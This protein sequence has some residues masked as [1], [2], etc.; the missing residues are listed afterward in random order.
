MKIKFL[1]TALAGLAFVGCN[2]IEDDFV[3]NEIAGQASP[4]TFVLSNDV[5]DATRAKF[6]EDINRLYYEKGDI[7]SLFNN[8]GNTFPTETTSSLTYENAVFSNV[9]GSDVNDYRTKAWV[10]DGTAI[11]VYPADVTTAWKTNRASDKIVVSINDKQAFNYRTQWPT[12]SDFMTIGKYTADGTENT[13]GYDRVYN[14][15]LKPLGSLLRLTLN[16]NAEQVKA[17]K[18]FEITKVELKN[19]TTATFSTSVQLVAGKNSTLTNYPKDGEYP[20]KHFKKQAEVASDPVK[21]VAAISTEDIE[22]GIAHFVLLPSANGIVEKASIVITTNYGTITVES[23]NNVD[24]VKPFANKSGTVYWSIKDGLSN[25]LKNSWVN[26][27]GKYNGANTGGV[28]SRTFSFDLTNMVPDAVKTSEQLI[29]VIDAYNALGRKNDITITLAPD[30]EF[31]LSNDALKAAVGIA[32]LKI[33]SGAKPI[34]LEKDANSDIAALF[35]KLN[36]T[37]KPKVILKGESVLK[38]SDAFTTKVI[39]VT[40]EGTLTINGDDSD[41]VFGEK[42]ILIN[43]G[44]LKIAGE[45]VKMG[46]VH[47]LAASAEGEDDSVINIAKGA[48]YIATSGA[49]YLFGEV[50]NKGIL[51]VADGSI[52]NYGKISNEGSITATATKIGS[53]SIVNGGEIINKN[54][55]ATIVLT[56][57]TIPANTALTLPACTGDVTLKKRTGG[58][59]VAGAPGYIKYEVKNPS[60][61]NPLSDNGDIFNYLVVTATTAT[62]IDV[63]SVGKDVKH[64]ELNGDVNN[65]TNSSAVLK[66]YTN[67]IVNVKNPRIVNVLGLLKGTNTYVAYVLNN[68]QTAVGA[69]T[70]FY[71]GTAKTSFASG[72][73]GKGSVQYEG[74]IVKVDWPTTP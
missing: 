72:T 42:F 2:Q 8:M 60:V 40:N 37:N 68:W 33:N 4:I 71:A 43:K 51:T 41:K 3:P 69:S 31:E 49:T 56:Q 10:Y 53:G 24:A 15:D 28:F 34:R 23:D 57:N 32:K 35:N 58:C 70:Y 7:F 18:D 17:L 12:V 73:Y 25:I 26:G 63:A 64:I 46:V 65:I 22:D 38:Q 67:I 74:K 21:K 48:E 59:E 9:E 30:E 11:M 6:D 14:L 16:P 50:S 55:N 13:E 45:G 27:E 54:V 36:F 29:A 61:T 20:F 39:E 66:T 19:G 52:Y 62:D 1:L 47:S 5:D 44:T